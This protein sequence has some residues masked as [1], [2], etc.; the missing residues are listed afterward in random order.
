MV[1]PRNSEQTLRKFI[2]IKLAFIN[3]C[4]QMGRESKKV[5]VSRSLVSY[6][7]G[8]DY[9][10]F[11][12]IPLPVLVV[13]EATACDYVFLFRGVCWHFGKQWWLSCSPTEWNHVQSGLLTIFF[14]FLHSTT[15]HPL[16]AMEMGISLHRGP[17]GEPGGGHIYQGFWETVTVLCNWIISLN[18]SCVREPWREGFFTGNSESYVK[19]VKE[20]YGNSASFSL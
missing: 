19:H 14:F 15:T 8:F 13:P 11:L 10:P 17:F 2:Q 1:T 7:A 9:I 5:S 18:G 6:K 12:V 20:C 4:M 3:A 16:K